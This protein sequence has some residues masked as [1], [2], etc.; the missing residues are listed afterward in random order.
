MNYKS[1]NLVNQEI[2]YVVGRYNSIEGQ[3]YL[4]FRKILIFDL[5]LR[6]RK[7][8]EDLYIELM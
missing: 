4:D 2:T 7:S 3:L 1:F 5:A 8:C 6:I